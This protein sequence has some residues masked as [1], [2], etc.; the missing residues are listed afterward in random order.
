MVSMAV[1]SAL[2]GC[3][4]ESLGFGPVEELDQSLQTTFARDGQHALDLRGVSGFFVG[5]IAEE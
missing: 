2:V 5:S 1:P 3:R 4:Q